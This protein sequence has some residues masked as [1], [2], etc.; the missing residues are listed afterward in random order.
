MP[1]R[2]LGY[3]FFDLTSKNS[4][5]FA[6]LCLGFDDN[7]A[8]RHLPADE[9]YPLPGIS[10]FT[11]FRINAHYLLTA[12]PLQSL[13]NKLLL[14][15]SDVEF[16]PCLWRDAVTTPPEPIGVTWRHR[17]HKALSLPLSIFETTMNV[18]F[19]PDDAFSRFQM[20]MGGELFALWRMEKTLVLHR[21]ANE[22]QLANLLSRVSFETI[23]KW[24]DND[25]PDFN[26][27]SLNLRVKNLALSPAERSKSSAYIRALTKGLSSGQCLSLLQR[28]DIDVSWVWDN[29]NLED[30]NVM[31]VQ[32]VQTIISQMTEI[33]QQQQDALVQVGLNMLQAQN[34]NPQQIQVTQWPDAP[35]AP[36]DPLPVPT[37]LIKAKRKLRM[38]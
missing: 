7:Y 23:L 28:R 8:I 4:P 17:I 38:P 34:V 3:S 26:L 24:I 22:D 20:M 27:R 21:D 5:V 9:H 18:F 33:Q 30:G 13:M 15:P 19:F 10:R 12:R 25:D 6:A 2:E 36:Q 29:I 1:A 32:V 31:L 16:L 14:R 37:E 11:Q 35:Q